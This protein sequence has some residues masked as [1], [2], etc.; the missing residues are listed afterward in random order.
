VRRFFDELWNQHRLEVIDELL[1]PD[2][3]L[4]AE[5][6]ERRGRAAAYQRATELFAAFGEFA[7]DIKDVTAHG[8]FV[9][10]RWRQRLNVQGSS[11]VRVENG[12]LTEGRDYWHEPLYG[13]V[14]H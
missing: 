5:G 13:V 11:W 12:W 6:Q 14:A 1:S 4:R 8:D 9:I 7:I 10:C 2:C 3:V